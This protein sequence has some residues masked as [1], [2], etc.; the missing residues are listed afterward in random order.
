MH[1]TGLGLSVLDT[2]D[3]IDDIIALRVV[4]DIDR[5]EGE[6]DEEFAKRGAGFCY[7]ALTLMRKLP[8]WTGAFGCIRRL[9]TRPL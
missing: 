5:F 3:N 1:K 8:N 9:K 7:H 6:G 2:Q 4:L